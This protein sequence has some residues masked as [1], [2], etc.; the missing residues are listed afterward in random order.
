[1]DNFEPILVDV[2]CSRYEEDAFSLLDKSRE[3]NVV[4]DLRSSTVSMFDQTSFPQLNISSRTQLKQQLYREQT[5]NSEPRA[6]P[7][8]PGAPGPG[9]LVLSVQFPLESIDIELPKK[10]LQVETKLENPTRYHVIQK[11]KT[12]VREYVTT[13]LKL[14]KQNL[15]RESCRHTRLMILGRLYDSF[16]GAKPQVGQLAPAGL[17]V[18]PGSVGP[19]APAQLP[20]GP[21][22]PAGVKEG[23]TVAGAGTGVPGPPTPHQPLGTPASAMPGATEQQSE[24]RLEMKLS[25]RFGNKRYRTFVDEFDYVRDLLGLIRFEIPKWLFVVSEF[26]EEISSYECSRAARAAQQLLQQQQLQQH[27]QQYSSDQEYL[28]RQSVAG[29]KGAKH[30]KF[31]EP[32]VRD[33]I[34]KDNHNCSRY[35]EAGSGGP[36][37]DPCCQVLPCAR[38]PLLT[39]VQLLKCRAGG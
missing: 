4:R 25:C 5:K 10:V 14:K 6:R 28:L 16:I 21:G 23:R 9:P 36:V 3:V 1:M 11:Q 2:D 27:Q 39:A 7:P 38:W 8:P 12:Q 29:E 32:E 20:N 37:L 15:V 31:I 34:K 30:E 22:G 33:R 26:E 18:G 24:W 19:V 17:V 13:A 35:R